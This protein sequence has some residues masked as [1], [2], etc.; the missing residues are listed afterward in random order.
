[1]TT[2]D[3]TLA[4]AATHGMSLVDRSDCRYTMRTTDV[5][6]VLGA[7]SAW[8]NQFVWKA[9]SYTDAIPNINKAP[10]LTAGRICK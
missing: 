9:K 8:F 10:T 2:Y 4:G 3:Q 7:E 1:M 5:M 6:T